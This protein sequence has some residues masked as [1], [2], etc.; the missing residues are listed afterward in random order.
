MYFN[1]INK[2][3]SKNL[4]TPLFSFNIMV[5]I[6]KQSIDMISIENLDKYLLF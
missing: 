5:V 1:I 6:R 4:F 2:G 3:S